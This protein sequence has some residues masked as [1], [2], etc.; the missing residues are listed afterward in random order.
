MGG[1]SNGAYVEGFF[2]PKLRYPSTLTSR[3]LC[4]FSM[5]TYKNVKTCNKPFTKLPPLSLLLPHPPLILSSSLFLL[6]IRPRPPLPLI[7]PL[8]HHPSFLHLFISLPLP[9]VF[10][11]LQVLPKPHESSPGQPRQSSFPLHYT[12]PI[13]PINSVL[14]PSAQPTILN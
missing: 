9:F 14:T 4:R 10:V 11:F 6:V 2:P 8:S 3:L 12:D 13:T 5:D 7:F 1:E